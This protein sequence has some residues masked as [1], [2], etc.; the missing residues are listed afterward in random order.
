[1]LTWRN[2]PEWGGVGD[3]RSHIYI[4]YSVKIQ[5]ICPTVALKLEFHR[6]NRT[7]RAE[8]KPNV[9]VTVGLGPMR[10]DASDFPGGIPALT[11]SAVN[12]IKQDII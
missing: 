3:Q 4:I 8:K 2:N 9:E 6:G 1:M 10:P 7:H 11:L 5:Q 12:I